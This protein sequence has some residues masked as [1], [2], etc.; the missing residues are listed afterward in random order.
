VGWP[1]V[2]RLII[3]LARRAISRTITL[4]SMTRI[5]GRR[6]RYSAGFPPDCDAAQVNPEDDEE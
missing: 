4:R 6:R 3:R 5:G 2:L 1:A